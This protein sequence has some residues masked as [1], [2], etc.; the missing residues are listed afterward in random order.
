MATSAETGHTSSYL[1]LAAKIAAVQ[2]DWF[3]AILLDDLTV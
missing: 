3:A 2:L 1:L